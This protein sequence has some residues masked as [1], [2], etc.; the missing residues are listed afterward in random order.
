[1]RRTLWGIGLML[2]LSLFTSVAASADVGYTP[3]AGSQSLAGTSHGCP[4][5]TIRL[6]QDPW[7]GGQF[8]RDRMP[9]RYGPCWD[10][11]A[12]GLHPSSWAS[13]LQAQC[14]SRTASW[15]RDPSQYA[16]LDCRPTDRE[17]NDAYYTGGAGIRTTPPSGG[18]TGTGT[19][20]TGTPGTGT[21]CPPCP[22]C[23]TCVAC[24]ETTVVYTRDR[25]PAEGAQVEFWDRL[26][27]SRHQGQR[28]ASGVWVTPGGSFADD[29]IYAWRP[30]TPTPELR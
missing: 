19:P 2:A 29:Q 23:P 14:E 9:L 15:I 10:R 26:I 12:P 21:T 1:M 16:R 7:A 25:M 5:H 28:H 8:K 11:G 3:P 27:R 22:A 13:I 17:V 6:D 18:G 4:R 30:V 24:V 20:G